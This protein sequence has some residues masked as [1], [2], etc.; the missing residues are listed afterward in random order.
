MELSALKLIPRTS[1]VLL[2][3]QLTVNGKP[4]LHGQAVLIP[5]VLL[6]ELGIKPDQG[7]KLQIHHYGAEMLALELMEVTLN[8]AVLSVLLTVTWET[9]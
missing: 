8:L 4:G 6:M 1:H 9:G 5:V 2:N 7:Q 3:A